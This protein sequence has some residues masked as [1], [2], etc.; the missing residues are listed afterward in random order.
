MCALLNEFSTVLLQ[1]QH[2]IDQAN[3]ISKKK[4]KQNPSYL[5]DDS[6]TTQ[7]PACKVELFSS[8]RGQKTN[9]SKLTVP[10]K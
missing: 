4:L 10:T 6:V 9:L 8:S 1:N 5:M 3:N 7:Y 2:C